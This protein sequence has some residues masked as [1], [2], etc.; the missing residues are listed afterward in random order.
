MLIIGAILIGMA[1]PSFSEVST[2][3]SARR[4]AQVFSRDLALARS[5]AV[6]GREQVVIRFYEGGTLWY[7]VVTASP[8]SAPTSRAGAA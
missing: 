5:M 6:R 4:A 8:T 3:A 1:A 7:E 2:R